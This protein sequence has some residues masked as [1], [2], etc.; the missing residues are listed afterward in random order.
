MNFF[1]VSTIA[2]G[3]ICLL[4]I[5]SFSQANSTN[6]PP[7]HIPAAPPLPPV[8]KSPVAVFREL[9]AMNPQERR[10]ALTNRTPEV[11]KQILAKV[12]EYESLKPN[13]R[14]LRLLST[15]LRWYMLN[16]M[17][18]PASNRVERMAELPAETRQLINDR[19]IAWDKLSPGDQAALL[20]N[21][22]TLQYF[23]EPP[24]QPSVENLSPQRQ[25]WLQEGIRQWKT[26]SEEQRQTIKSRFDQ[27]FQLTFAEQSKAVFT[28]SDAD[29][30]QIE[31]TLRN[32]RQLTPGER[33]LCLE[34]FEKFANLSVAERQQFLKNAERWN[35][36]T[37][38]Q[39]KAW[40]D[41]VTKLHQPPLPPGLEPPAPPNPANRGS[42]RFATNQPQR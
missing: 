37:L 33:T 29:K 22:A 38:D 10:D 7:G 25:A 30:K 26:L 34:S 8:G 23:S 11:R 17:P 21:Q 2:I 6:N 3:L 9:L 4:P 31:R 32:F 41:L 13:Q 18:V 14:E 16:L 12:R 19:L 1:P 36:M 39:R 40:C 42:A 5:S 20:T 24:D 27:F 28:L 35:L 15:E